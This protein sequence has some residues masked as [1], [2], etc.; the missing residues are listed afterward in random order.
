MLL[1]LHSLAEPFKTGLP[2]LSSLLSTVSRVKNCRSTVVTTSIK[3]RV[4]GLAKSV[5]C[6]QVSLY[7]GSFA[8]ILLLLG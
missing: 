3:Q 2:T 4:K 6:N 5:R 1:S 7:Q 8:Y